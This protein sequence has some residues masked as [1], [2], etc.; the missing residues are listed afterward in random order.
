MDAEVIR[1]TIEIGQEGEQHEDGGEEAHRDQHQCIGV[2]RGVVGR[3]L[4]PEGVEPEPR[5]PRIVAG[6]VHHSPLRTQQVELC[7]LRR[8]RI[9]GQEEQRLGKVILIEASTAQEQAV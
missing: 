1:Q 6:L 8:Q 2:R 3:D 9:L 7:R 4:V 5:L